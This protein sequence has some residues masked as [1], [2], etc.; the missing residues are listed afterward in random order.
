[1]EPEAYERLK[2]FSDKHED[3][4]VGEA[5]DELIMC[6]INKQGDVTVNPVKA[7]FRK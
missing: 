6:I 1:M 5:L 4:T 3:L 7:K 2:E